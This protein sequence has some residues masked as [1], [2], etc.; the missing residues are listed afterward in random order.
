MIYNHNHDNLTDYVLNVPF[1]FKLKQIKYFIT[2]KHLC[3][4]DLILRVL[5]ELEKN[6]Y[7]QF[8]RS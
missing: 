3:G 7:S 2:T 6:K 4:F 1:I 8:I 5:R